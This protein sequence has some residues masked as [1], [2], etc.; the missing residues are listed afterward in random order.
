M[1]VES[2]YPFLSAK[3]KARYL[4]LNE[5]RAQ[6]WPIACECRTID[7]A[8]GSTFVRVSG[9]IDGPPLVL[10]P[11]GGAS[12]PCLPARVEGDLLR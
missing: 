9:P 1:N 10:L 5:R 3:A 7:T 4:E 2:Y 6:S 8:H 12:S 11:G